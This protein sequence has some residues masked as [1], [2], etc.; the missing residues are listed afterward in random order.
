VYCLDTMNIKI[1]NSF[2]FEIISFFDCQFLIYYYC[3]CTKFAALF[4]KVLNLYKVYKHLNIYK[5]VSEAL[6]QAMLRISWCSGSTLIM[7]LDPEINCWIGM[8]I[9]IEINADP[10]YRYRDIHSISLC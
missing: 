7:F 5:K 10:K 2:S 4:L 3:L 1:Q 8:R 6:P 9:H